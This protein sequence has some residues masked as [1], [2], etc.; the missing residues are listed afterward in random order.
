MKKLLAF[1]AL[2]AFGS[3]LVF[4]SFSQRKEVLH[5]VEN[6]ELS[7]KNFGAFPVEIPDDQFEALFV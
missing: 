4:R 5:F 1:I 6:E 7:E 2:G 3:F